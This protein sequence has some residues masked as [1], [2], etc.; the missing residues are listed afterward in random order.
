MKL[1]VAGPMTGYEEDNYPAFIRA[2][3]QLRSRG[4]ETLLPTDTQKLNTTGVRQEWKWYVRHGLHMLLDAD[5]IAVLP[6]WWKSKGATLEVHI[7]T[8]LQFPVEPVE[9]WLEKAESA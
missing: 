1:Y 9:F 6:N 2:G 3:K 8:Q 4:Y 7:A 5:G